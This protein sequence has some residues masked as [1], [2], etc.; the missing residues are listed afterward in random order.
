MRAATRCSTSSRPRPASAASS[1][2]TTT[3]TAA[4]RTRYA[5]G[6]ARRAAFAARLRAAGL[7]KGRHGRDLGREPPRMDRRAVG[8]PARRRRRRADRLPRVGGFPRCASRRIVDARADPGRRR[9]GRRLDRRDAAGLALSELRPRQPTSTGDAR[10]DPR[11]GPTSPRDDDRRDHLHLRRDGRAQGRRHHAPQHPREHRPDRA[12]DGEV[13]AVRDAVPADPLPEPA[14]AQPHVRA[15]DGDVRPA[16]ARGTSSSSRAATRPTTSSGRS[17]SG[18]SRCSSACR[19]SSTC[20]ASTSLRVAPEAAEPPPA[21]DAL[22]EALVAL[23]PR[24]TALFGFKFWAIVVGAAPLDP[25]LEAFWGGSGFVVVQG[26]GLTETAPIVTLNHPLHADAGRRRQADRRR[27][28]EDRRRRRDPRARRERH[29]AATTTRRRRPR[30]AR[31]R[32]A[33]S[34]PATSASSTRRAA[35]HPGRKKE[36]IVTPEGLNVF[37][38]DVERVLND[39]ARRPRRRRRRRAAAGGRPRSACTRCSSLEPATDVGRRSSARRTRGCRIIRRS[40]RVALWPGAELPRTEGT[41]KLKRRELRQWLAVRRRGPTAR[42]QRARPAC[43]ASQSVLAA[44]RARARTI[45]ADDDD[46]RA[47]PELARA[48]RADDGARRGVPGHA[49]RGARSRRRATVGGPRGARAADRRR[50]PRRRAIVA[51][52]RAASRSRRGTDRRRRARSGA[53]ACRPGSCRSRGSS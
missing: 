7:A 41:R 10:P 32:T 13:H 3:A 29:D 4:G 16:D 49:R 28:G 26:Y 8:L 51:A 31:S 50:A 24:S 53:S 15:V 38:E 2:S 47:G 1:S 37:P 44:L 14:A 23:P 39:A 40:A 46:R 5:R 43:A 48:R 42:P 20:C 19:R 9:R 33:G 35:A 27:R 17:A 21:G 36:M 45:A 18:A 30:A 6:R 12:R 25:E 52:R 22:G 34:T 11:R